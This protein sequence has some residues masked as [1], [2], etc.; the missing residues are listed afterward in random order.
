[1]SRRDRVRRAIV[2]L[3]SAAMYADVFGLPHVAKPL[4]TEATGLL[5]VAS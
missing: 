5:E 3:D 1:M 4:V 2:L